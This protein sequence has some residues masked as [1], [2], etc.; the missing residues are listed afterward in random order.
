[1]KQTRIIF[2][3]IMLFDTQEY[4]QLLINP[5]SGLIEGGAEELIDLGE[6][7]NVGNAVISNCYI[8]HRQ[9]HKVSDTAAESALKKKGVF[10]FLQAVGYI[11]IS[12]CYLPPAV[13][14]SVLASAFMIF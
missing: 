14:R 10:G 8:R 1:M 12:L 5:V 13:E 7:L 4:V 3:V 6:I 11:R 2:Q 9:L